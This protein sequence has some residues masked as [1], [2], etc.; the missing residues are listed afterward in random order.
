[1]LTYQKNSNFYEAL[2]AE[3]STAACS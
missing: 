3:V 1:M 2:K